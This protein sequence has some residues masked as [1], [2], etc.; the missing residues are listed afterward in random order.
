MLNFLA[1]GVLV[2]AVYLPGS[3]YPK[4]SFGSEGLPL[5][6]QLASDYIIEQTYFELYQLIFCY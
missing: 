5:E 2:F 1:V 3:A 4:N 6:L